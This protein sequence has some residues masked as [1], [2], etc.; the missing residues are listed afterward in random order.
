MPISHQPGRARTCY[1]A[2]LKLLYESFLTYQ[3]LCHNSKYS[4]TGGQ[5]K[6]TLENT[7][8]YRIPARRGAL[9]PEILHVT[10]NP[11][12]IMSFDMLEAIIPKGISICSVVQ[13]IARQI[14]D[15]TSEL[16][17]LRLF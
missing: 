12:E 6:S 4:L 10:Q 1:F 2:G 13:E 5:N 9:H 14:D 7:A 11:F 16:V 8:K 17:D 15:F 3:V